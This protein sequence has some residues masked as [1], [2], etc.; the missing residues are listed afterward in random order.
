[1]PWSFT[2]GRFAGVAVRAH[3]TFIVFLVWIG[4]AGWRAGGPTAAF[5]SVAFLAVL[6]ACVTLHEFGHILTARRFGKAMMLRAARPGSLFSRR[7]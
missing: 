4:V 1:M 7:A 3:V 6:F 2:I 5:G